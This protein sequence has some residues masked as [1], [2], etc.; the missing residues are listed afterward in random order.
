MASDEVPNLPAEASRAPEETIGASHAVASSVPR[1]VRN[2]ASTCDAE[3]TLQE[4]KR[5]C[6]VG[7]AGETHERQHK[8]LAASGAKAKRA[9][10]ARETL[11]I[12]GAG[13]YVAP[14]TGETVDIADVLCSAVVNSRHVAGGNWHEPTPRATQQRLISCEV[15]CC[16]TLAAAQDLASCSDCLD[17]PGVLNFASA[18]N[19]GGGFTTGA[20]AQEES[21]A[22]SSGLYP[23]L[24]KHFQAFF[25]P[26]RRAA[27]GLYTH[28][29]IHS[30]RVPVLRN[31]HGM[32]LDE[33]YLVDFVTAA[34]PN[35]GVLKGR[36]GERE[37]AVQC[38]ASLRER[39]RRVLHMFASNGCTDIVLGAWGCGVFQNDP[40]TVAMLFNEALNEIP[41]FRKVVFAVLDP[42]MAEIF[43]QVLK[44]PVQGHS[45]KGKVKPCHSH[46]ENHVAETMPQPRGKG[47]EKGKPQSEQ[48][49]KAEAQGGQGVSRK[50]RRWQQGQRNG[51][52]D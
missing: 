46:V 6:N 39:V 51:Y 25:E 40:E 18:R 17:A 52:G 26:H 2:A 42:A 21:L 19:P 50:P 5:L 23:C 48:K 35:C 37:A 41:Y 45:G 3:V 7:T 31:E 11:E 28:G 24:S 44:V 47:K 33:P 14:E 15:R 29:L 20:E 30:P 13:K 43:G 4:V 10:H 9:Q 12:L 34:A 38:N 49:D 22:R 27:S 36:C 32:L 16:T 1:A 8:A